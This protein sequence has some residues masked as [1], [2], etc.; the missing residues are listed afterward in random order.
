MSIQT[1][2]ISSK[3]TYKPKGKT[4]PRRHVPDLSQNVFT[5]EDK[6]AIA[7]AARNAFLRPDL[8][9]AEDKAAQKQRTALNDR[10]M[11]L[12][13]YLRSKSTPTV[14]P[15]LV[16]PVVIYKKIAKRTKQSEGSRSSAASGD[17]NAD[18]PDP[19]P[20]QKK[21][22]H[23]QLFDQKSL[24]ALLGIS[25]KT[26]QNWYSVSPYT[27]PEAIQIPHARGPRWTQ[28]AVE[29]WL[30][31]RPRHTQ[32]TQ[33]VAPVKSKKRGRPRIAQAAAIV[34]GGAK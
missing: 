5:I 20:E 19:E 3:S 2:N 32:K 26:L 12:F 33:P 22:H 16:K 11:R 34:A 18:D 4:S 31:N 30:N 29:K 9:T 13:C 25:K 10:R 1:Q 21:Q 7:R 14:K 8:A 28:K 15:Q 23:L 6:L 17:S 24:A 27:L